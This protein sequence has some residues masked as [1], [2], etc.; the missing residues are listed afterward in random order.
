MRIFK[1][2]ILGSADEW[3]KSSNIVVW[4]AYTAHAMRH[5]A[6]HGGNGLK[7][8]SEKKTT[9]RPGSAMFRTPTTLHSGNTRRG[10]SSPTRQSSK[11][12][13][14]E[15]TQ[16]FH[17]PYQRR[18]T[19]THDYVIDQTTY[20]VTAEVVP[21]VGNPSTTDSVE[22]TLHMSIRRASSG[23]HSGGQPQTLDQPLMFLTR[24][25]LKDHVEKFV[26]LKLDD[27]IALTE[28]D[29]RRVCP[30]ASPDQ[31]ATYLAY[32]RK[33]ESRPR[34]ATDKELLDALHLEEALRVSEIGQFL[35]GEA[36]NCEETRDWDWLRVADQ[37]Q[38]HALLHFGIT[39]TGDN[40]ALFRDAALHHG[41][42]VYVRNNVSKK[43]DL[44]VGDDAVNVPLLHIERAYN[45]K[46]LQRTCLF[47]QME[48]ASGR[49]LVVFAGSYT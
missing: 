13:P 39:P 21:A 48:M 9:M 11:P 41:F 2:G 31:I 14:D 49:P 47:D 20:H 40:L 24:V 37:M 32:A 10:G 15:T 44:R 12:L 36:E 46:S 29:V 22:H 27:L 43:G 34:A 33:F 8:K 1:S 18:H 16:T 38:A 5:R 23:V 28:E 26:N 45:C 25:G 30:A 3:S 6:S 42:S 19:S 35:F 4:D 17:A 7:K